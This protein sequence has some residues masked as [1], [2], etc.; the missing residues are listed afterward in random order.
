MRSAYISKTSLS[1]SA[2]YKYQTKQGIET[3]GQRILKEMSKPELAFNLLPI[4]I[5]LSILHSRLNI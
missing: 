4:T 2:E 1:F 3:T 5:K